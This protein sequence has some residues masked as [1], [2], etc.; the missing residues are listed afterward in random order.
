MHV[1]GFFLFVLGAVVGGIAT[2]FLAGGILTGVGAG[3]GIVT[4]LKAGACLTVEAAKNEGLIDAAQVDQ[5]LSAAGRQFATS[6]VPAGS[7]GGLTDAQC[8]QLIAEMKAAASN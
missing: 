6:D 4:G 1:K 5:V 2:F 7:E 3:A 8:Q